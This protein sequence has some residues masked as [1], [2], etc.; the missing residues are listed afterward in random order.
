MMKDF[1]Y[2]TLIALVSSIIS[3]SVA[4]YV[5]TQQKK[6]AINY[7][8]G[9]L[10]VDHREFNNSDLKQAGFSFQY[11]NEEIDSY[12]LINIELYNYT[13]I[14]L[15]NVRV[16]VEIFPAREDS[17][18]IIEAKAMD[19]DDQTEGIKT[20]TGIWLDSVSY[21]SWVHELSVDVV[22]TADSFAKPFFKASYTIITNHKPSVKVTI[23]KKGFDITPHKYEHFYKPSI[24]T[25]DG[26]VV[27][28][29]GAFLVLYIIGI[30]KIS[31]Y[32]SGRVNKRKRKFQEQVLTEE[33][34]KK[35]FDP[36]SAKS[37]LDTLTKINRK[38]EYK[39]TSRLKRFLYG[40]KDPEEE[41][42][43]S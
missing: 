14:N 4:W 27:I 16:L 37:I 33:I 24:F 42:A 20:I 26:A 25:S 18:K 7:I 23:K 2:K 17:I 3:A 6:D 43:K 35:N 41:E 29:C 31:N 40:I 32:S 22:N 8:D 21:T 12:S 15:E 13:Q 9:Y 5:Y 11:N 30:V 19:A 28:Y 36:E 38:F 34:H 10:S 39:D 1:F